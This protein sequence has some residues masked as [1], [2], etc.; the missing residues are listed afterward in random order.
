MISHSRSSTLLKLIKVAVKLEVIYFIYGPAD[1]KYIYPCSCRSDPEYADNY[2]LI[3]SMKFN[4]F[5]C[6][7]K[8]VADP[9]ISEGMGHPRNREKSSASF[10]VKT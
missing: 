3:W 2:E 8:S 4:K 10:G 7:I 1:V 5:T 6:M 9:E